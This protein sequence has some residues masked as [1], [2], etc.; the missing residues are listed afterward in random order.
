M[1]RYDSGKRRLYDLSARGNW[2]LHKH[3]QITRPCGSSIYDLSDLSKKAN[4]RVV[5]KSKEQEQEQEQEQ[6]LI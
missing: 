3:K 1:E 5:A 6:E 2:D 4:K